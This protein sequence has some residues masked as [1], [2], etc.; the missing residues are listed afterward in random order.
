MYLADFQPCLAVLL[1]GEGW[2]GPLEYLGA[3]VSRSIRRQPL[4]CGCVPRSTLELVPGSG[5][6]PEC[7]R[8]RNS[9]DQL[10]QRA[11]MPAELD[12]DS[13]DAGLVLAINFRSARLGRATDPTWG[14]RELSGVAAALRQQAPALTAP[15]RPTIWCERAAETRTRSSHRSTL[16]Q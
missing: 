1:L 6:H 7:A 16:R 12:S 10:G 9:L 15:R 2:R 8:H 4:E 13:S 3:P 14:F 5:T 11:F